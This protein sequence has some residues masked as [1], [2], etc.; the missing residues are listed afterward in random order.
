MKVYRISAEDMVKLRAYTN[1]LKKWIDYKDKDL[2]AREID[3]EVFANIVV[4][5]ELTEDMEEIDNKL[6]I[7]FIREMEKRH[8]IC[9]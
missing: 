1:D 9:C 6:V 5:C 3:H 7:N 2:L 8:E 4:V